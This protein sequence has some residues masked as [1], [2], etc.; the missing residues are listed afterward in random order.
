[1]L[2]LSLKNNYGLKFL[3]VSWNG[4]SKDGACSLCE[5]LQS[6]QTLQELNVKANRISLEACLKVSSALAANCSLR[7]LRLVATLSAPIC[8]VLLYSVDK[9]GTELQQ[10]FILTASVEPLRMMLVVE[11]SRL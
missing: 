7:V 3:D 10:H 1:M 6:N 2:G 8:A 4:F 9:S 11:E 5:G